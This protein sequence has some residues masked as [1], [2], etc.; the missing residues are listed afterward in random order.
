[1]HVLEDSL[2]HV[3]VD[4]LLPVRV[5]YRAPTRTARVKAG[6]LRSRNR[7]SF[8]YRILELYTGTR[9]V[10]TRITHRKQSRALSCML[11]RDMTLGISA[12]L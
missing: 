7:K 5:L 3:H 11:L 8:S 2:L 9:T 1:M 6:I 12:A 4:T 10:S